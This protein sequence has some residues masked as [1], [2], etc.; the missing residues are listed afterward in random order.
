M[1]YRKSEVAE[2]IFLFQKSFRALDENK[3]SLK[4]STSTLI[5]SSFIG[6]RFLQQQ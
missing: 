2:I 6:E 5:V 3:P 4:P 1:K